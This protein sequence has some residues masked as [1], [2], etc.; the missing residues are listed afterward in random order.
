MTKVPIWLRAYV[1]S[2]W[3]L[4]STPLASGYMLPI[5]IEGR[6]VDQAVAEHARLLIA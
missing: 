5:P 2:V 4:R 6:S 3:W 1:R